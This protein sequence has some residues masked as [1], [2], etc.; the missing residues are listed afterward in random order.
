[1]AY[2]DVI[3]TKEPVTTLV[4]PPGAQEAETDQ[5]DVIGT[6]DPVMVIVPGVLPGAH[7]AEIA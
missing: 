1:M 4:P 2:D 6:N 7:E 5:L 3:G